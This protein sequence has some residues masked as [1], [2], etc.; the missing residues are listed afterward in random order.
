MRFRRQDDLLCRAWWRVDAREVERL[1]RATAEEPL[2]RALFGAGGASRDVLER[3]LAAWLRLPSLSEGRDS[4][5]RVLR[6]Y[7]VWSY[8][9]ALAQMVLGHRGE[10]FGFAGPPG[11]GKTTLVSATAAALRALDPE[12]RVVGVSL[13]D[14]YYSKAERSARGLKWRAQPGAHDL[15]AAEALLDAVRRK[16]EGV[17]APRFDHRSDRPLPPEELRGPI[18]VLL[19]EGWFVGRREDGYARISDRLDHLTFLDAPIELAR[20]RRFARERSLRAGDGVHRGLS[21]REMRSF[22]REVLA[23]GTERWVRPIRDRADLV[24]SLDDDGEVASAHRASGRS[25]PTG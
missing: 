17:R 12:L 23:P 15:G 20:R 22:W 6:P 21:P 24:I 5:W 3:R 25:G 14:F 8:P 16:C 18:S 19:L 2:Q 7:V 10:I 11:V 9:F 1:F 13:D 4:V